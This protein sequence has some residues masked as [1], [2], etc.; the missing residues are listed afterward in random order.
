MKIA[1][2]SL[3]A[4]RRRSTLEQWRVCL[5]VFLAFS[6]LSPL[7][8]F[9]FDKVKCEKCGRWVG[10]LLLNKQAKSTQPSAR[11]RISFLIKAAASQEPVS[12]SHSSSLASCTESEQN[13]QH[14][15]LGASNPSRNPTVAPVP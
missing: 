4:Q 14:N 12:P 3:T 1:K 5:L 13:P 9:P 11:T 6:S 7:F 2:N 15:M 8:S 10:C